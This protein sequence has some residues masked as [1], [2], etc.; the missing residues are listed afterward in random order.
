MANGFAKRLAASR[1]TRGF[2]ASELARLVGVTSTAVWNWEKNGV[3]P[4]PE[5]LA[6]IARALGVT[7]AYLHGGIVEDAKLGNQRT[8]AEV[9][10]DAQREIASI[11]GMPPDRITIKVEFGTN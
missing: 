1:E 5:M 9:I 11:M 6:K 3:T 7:E 10:D 2:S 4:R 8:V